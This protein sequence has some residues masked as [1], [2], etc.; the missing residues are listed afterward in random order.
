MTIQILI[1]EQEF[2]LAEQSS[3]ADAA[4]A[5]GA[6]MP[7]A[8]LLNNKFIPASEHQTTAIDNHDRIE[9]ISAIQGG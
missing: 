2:E 3:L 5:F 1:N 7:F 6:T 8:L 4:Q 9:I